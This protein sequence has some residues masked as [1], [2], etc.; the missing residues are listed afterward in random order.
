MTKPVLILGAG[1]HAKVLVEA[2]LQSGVMITGITDPDPSLAGTNILG[3]PV[4]G[5][6]HLVHNCQTSDIFLVNG[7]GSVGLPTRRKEL[8]ERFQK[9]G[10]RFANVIHP[11]TII[12]SD[13]IL[14]EG[15]QIMA[16]S[17]IQPGCRIGFN[18]IVNTR[19]SVD[20]DCLIGNHVHIAPGVT[21]S[22][23][24]Q[25]GDCV[26]IGT[27]ASM[28]QGISIGNNSLIAAGAVV[29]SNVIAMTKVRGV[30]AMEFV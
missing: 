25:I 29:I 14:G 23:D 6:D 20:H 19:V 13:A 28:I 12:A 15:T 18:S 24:V 27:G 2:L 8:F 10:Y 5:D 22:G 26:H 3:V 7:L 9:S 4:L 16:G 1:G 17:V 30:P 11:S 21:L